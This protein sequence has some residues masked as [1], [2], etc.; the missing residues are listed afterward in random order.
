[1][2]LTLYYHPLSSF[3]QKALIALYENGAAFDKRIIN[4]GD[5]AD[6]AELEAI[7]PICKFPVLRDSE[8]RRDV[9]ETSILIEYLDQ[10]YPGAARLLPADW[11]AAL[12][13]RLWDRFFDLYVQGPVQTIVGAH[14]SGLSC[15]Q[16]KE[17]T[18]LKTAYKM[19]EKRMASRG[20]LC[21][22][23]FSMADCAAAPALFYAA[24]LVPFPEQ[25][26][27]LQSYFER[28]IAR[29]SVQRVLE[30]AK[31]YF[32]MYPFASDIPERFL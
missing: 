8:H 5:Q 4:L 27:H 22:E 29:P 24:T 25:Y 16:T 15:D 28:L 12:D 23:S 17:R 32:S 18:K 21:G 2:S 7:W 31:P 13:V 14:L 6:R 19:I 20:W 1:M 9:P 11:E 3:C 10:R 30:E 26:H